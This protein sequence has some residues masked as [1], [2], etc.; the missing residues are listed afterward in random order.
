M[1]TVVSHGYCRTYALMFDFS[2]TVWFLA[3]MEETN[4]AAL[5]VR[6]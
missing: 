6:W 2:S 4:F 5:N 1:H 3:C